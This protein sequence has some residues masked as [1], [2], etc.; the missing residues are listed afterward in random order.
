MK[1]KICIFA[2]TTEGRRL[3]EILAESYEITVCTATGY[4]EAALDN[5]G[6]IAVRAGRMDAGEIADFI[7]REGFDRVIDATHPYALDITE[8]ISAAAK[9]ASIPVM[10]I[11]RE[12]DLRIQ[13]AVYVSSVKEARDYLAR[14]EGNIL[15]TTGSKELSEYKGLDMSRVWARVL[16]TADALQT[17]ADAG[18]PASNI[19]AA[20]GPFTYEMNLAQLNMIGAGF[21]VTKASGRTG[22]FD[23]KISAAAAAG[24][25]PVVIGRP[26]QTEGISLDE[27]AFRLLAN[28]EHQ[29]RSIVLIGVGPGSRELTTAQANA[30]LESCDAVIGAGSV[31][32]TLNTRKPVFREYKPENIRKLLE[33]HPSIRR[34]A[35]ALR[36]DAGF[37]SAAKNIV[38]EFEDYEISVIPGI[39]SVSLFASRLG[40]SY[41][42][43]AIVSLHGRRRNIIRLVDRNKKTF[44]LCGGDHTPGSI[45][46]KLCEYGLEEVFVAVGERLSYPDEI[47][48]RGTADSLKDT[49]FDPLSVMYIENPRACARFRHGMSDDC[50]T[51]GDV[52]MT[53]SEA[54]S[55]ILSQLELTEDAVIWDIGAG[56]GSVSIECALAANEGQVFAIEKDEDAVGLIRENQI[57]H[58][59]DNIEIIKGRAPDILSGLPAPTHVFI[60]GSSGELKEI[61]RAVLRI[62][63]DARI[64]ASA[65]TLETQAELTS[66]GELFGFSV[67]KAVGVSVSR[68]RKAGR[69][70]LMN[71]Q[72]PVTVF[73]MQ[74]GKTDV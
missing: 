2:G 54:R 47:I 33:K 37:F 73:T 16:P 42:D 56:T 65:V 50:F 10:R 20:Q 41:D 18:V 40:I 34:A 64:V 68:A 7:I 6:G 45:C 70:H 71:S 23:E 48:T 26:P 32:E 31:V 46:R 14:Q 24:A 11:L 53:K 74:G 17:C 49:S 63:P 57:R 51:R 58:R 55:I 39:S 36:G 1:D 59:A 22:G 30:A 52:P 15:I 3:A 44:V 8:N 35:V 29:K 38:K 69:Y 21:L 19:I 12:D 9:K 62:S 43:A 13:N 27:A 67:F 5:I 61:I 4:G 25:I 28:T 66:C 72:N 60:G